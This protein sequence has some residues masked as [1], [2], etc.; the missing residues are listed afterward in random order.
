ML[1]RVPLTIRKE[2]AKKLL[3]TFTSRKG[4]KITTPSNQTNQGAIFSG[5]FDSK[6]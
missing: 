1:V 5:R 6:R 4:V 2:R 3:I